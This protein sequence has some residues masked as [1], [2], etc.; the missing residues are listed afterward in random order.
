MGHRHR[1][2]LGGVRGSAGGQESGR[3]KQRQQPPRR[4]LEDTYL[5]LSGSLQTQSPDQT[6]GQ[7]RAQHT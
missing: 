3:E 1:T 2:Y 5:S 6:R 7:S 4:K